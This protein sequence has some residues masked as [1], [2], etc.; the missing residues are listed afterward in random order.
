MILYGGLNPVACVHEA[1]VEV[2]NRA[3]STVMEYQ[4]LWN[5]W[6]LCKSR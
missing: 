6:E 2:E 5:F 1:G 4:G 3:M